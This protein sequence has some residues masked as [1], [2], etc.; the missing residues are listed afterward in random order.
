MIFFY[1]VFKK[2]KSVLQNPADTIL[3]AAK[4][5]NIKLDP[6]LIRSCAGLLN[7]IHVQKLILNLL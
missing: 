4:S 5:M 3:R 2:K 7:W 1:V 6:S